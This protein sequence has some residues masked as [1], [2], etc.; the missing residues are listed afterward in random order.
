M[1]SGRDVIRV[2]GGIVGR[3]SAGACVLFAP[4]SGV[5]RVRRDGRPLTRT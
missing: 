4:R 1:R 2:L 5:R 3:D